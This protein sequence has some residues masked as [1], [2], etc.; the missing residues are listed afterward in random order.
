MKQYFTNKI[1]GW[2]KGINR[3]FPWKGEKDPYLIWL[4]EVI[5]QQTRVNQGLPY[6]IKFKDLTFGK[7]MEIL[8]MLDLGASKAILD[9]QPQSPLGELLLSISNDVIKQL[10]GKLKEYTILNLSVMNVHL[11]DQ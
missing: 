6:F 7:L 3:P 2:H 8:S 4:S 9:N 10:Q 1:L 11:S 5:L